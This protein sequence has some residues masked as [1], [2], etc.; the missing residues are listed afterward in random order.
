MKLEPS[1]QCNSRL[2][3][4]EWLQREHR[5]QIEVWLVFYKKHTGK[6]SVSY[7][8]SVEEA[9]CFGWIDGLK[10]RVDDE[11]YAHRF[12]PRRKRSRWS[13]LN[14]QLAGK[15]IDEGRM[16][17]AGMTAFQ[18]RESYGT[19]YAETK[20]EPAPSLSKNSEATLWTDPLA[21]KNFNALAPGYRKQYTLW[22][23]TA[24]RPETRD[25]RLGEAIEL[26]RENRKLGMK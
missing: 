14:V 6:T 26:L 1:I 15:M 19:G 11:R 2:E 3:W 5:S 20:N 25:K 23:E 21:W 16:A 13:P 10:R 12:T 24:K 4:R 8:E 22:I 17:E 7:R 18:Q 9:I